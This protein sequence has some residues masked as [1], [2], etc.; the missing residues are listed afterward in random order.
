MVQTSQDSNPSQPAWEMHPIISGPWEIHGL[1]TW[2][3]IRGLPFSFVAAK[4]VTDNCIFCSQ[5]KQW[6][7]STWGHTSLGRFT[8]LPL[9]DSFHRPLP[10]PSVGASRYASTIIKY[11][12]QTPLGDSHSLSITTAFSKRHS[13][14]Y[15][16]ASGS[17]N[18]LNS[19][20]GP[21]LASHTPGNY[22]PHIPTIIHSSKS[23]FWSPLAVQLLPPW[24][25]PFI[26]PLAHLPLSAMLFHHLVICFLLLT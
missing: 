16:Q 1:T 18:G 20:P 13:L 15:F 7:L 21:H 25:H 17:Q 14:N 11:S 23:H 8:M 24:Q 22:I 10:S 26:F 5:T 9:A 3:Q 12:H 2:A 4:V 19:C 6:E